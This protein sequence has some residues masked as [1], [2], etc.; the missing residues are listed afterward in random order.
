MTGGL[1]RG[2]TGQVRRRPGLALDTDLQQL[3]DLLI[4]EAETRF[5]ATQQAVRIDRMGVVCWGT[6]DRQR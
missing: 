5:A 1:L 6:Q 3:F 4:A 2:S